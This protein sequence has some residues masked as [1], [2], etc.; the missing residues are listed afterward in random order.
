MSEPAKRGDVSRRLSIRLS[1][2]A[3]QAVEEIS[4]LGGGKSVQEAIRR[5]LGDQLFFLRG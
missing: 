1:P 3:R 5:A 2:E 4:K